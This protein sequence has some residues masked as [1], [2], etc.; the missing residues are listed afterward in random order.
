MSDVK[1]RP[2]KG[3]SGSSDVRVF[4]CLD[5]ARILFQYMDVWDL[6]R[7]C[8]A[9]KTMYAEV[10]AY[11]RR[12]RRRVFHIAYTDVRVDVSLYNAMKRHFTNMMWENHRTIAEAVMYL[13]RRHVYHDCRRWYYIVNQV[14]DD[15]N[16]FYGYGEFPYYSMEV[17]GE[18]DSDIDYPD[19]EE[20]IAAVETLCI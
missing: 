6:G 1:Y 15:W 11:V 2:G 4:D 19:E 9:S 12:N 18:S 16:S 14:V 5:V 7:L 10:Q 13:E 3:T 8:Q 17:Y 20:E